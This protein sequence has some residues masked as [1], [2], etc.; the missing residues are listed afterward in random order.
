MHQDIQH[1]GIKDQIK[2]HQTLCQE[3]SHHYFGI[4]LRTVSHLAYMGDSLYG[5]NTSDVKLIKTAL[6][7]QQGQ[8]Q[9]IHQYL[10]KKGKDTFQMKATH[11]VY[12]DF[13]L[14]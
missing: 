8:S 7:L 4:V 5:H 12:V 2:T 13:A 1:I 10:D 11:S 6:K 3:M 14:K 9:Y